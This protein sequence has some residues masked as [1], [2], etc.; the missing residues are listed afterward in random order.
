MSVLTKLRNNF[1]AGVAVIFPIFLTIAIVRWVFAKVNDL[2]LAPLTGMLTPYL[3]DEY[4]LVAVKAVLFILVIAAIVII[5]LATRI[6]ILRRVFNFGEKWVY[7]IPMAG[8][9]Y[10]AVK[11]MSSAFLGEGKTLFKEVIMLEY[12]RRGIYSLGFTTA[13]AAGAVRDKMKEEALTAFV[14]T[15]PNPT[16]GVFLIVPKSEAIFLDMTVEDALKLVI[17]GGA[18]GSNSKGFDKK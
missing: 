4:L 3:A 5:G 7:K 16:S 6:L 11:H 17:S 14:P 2:L 8:R 9:I 18:A 15:S 13:M 10:G 1:A 12:P